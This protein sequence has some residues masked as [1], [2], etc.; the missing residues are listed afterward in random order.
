ME[1]LYV[2]TV[3]MKN[4]WSGVRYGLWI[5]QYDMAMFANLIP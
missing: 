5:I 4:T 2:S 1:D 3:K